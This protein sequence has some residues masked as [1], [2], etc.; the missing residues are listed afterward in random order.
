[1][2]FVGPDGVIPEMIEMM[3]TKAVI[4]KNMIEQRGLLSIQEVTEKSNMITRRLCSLIQYDNASRVMA[5]M[6]YRNEVATGDFIANC[7]RDGKRVAI[8]KVQKFPDLALLP[9][10]ITDPERDV[11][12]GFKGIPEPDASR[13]DTVDP[14]EFDLVVIPAAAFDKGRNRI[15]YGAGYYDRFLVTLRPDCLKVGIAYKM[16]I[17]DKF[18]ADVYDIPMDLV[19]TENRIY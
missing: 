8:P 16:Q 9:Y 19:I 5:Y 12:E 10:E 2:R 18:S 14:L 13:L 3:D 7:I 15:G 17:L 4:R 1:M 11:M 6:S